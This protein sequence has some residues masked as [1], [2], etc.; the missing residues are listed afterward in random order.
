MKIKSKFKIIILLIGIAFVFN[1]T[2]IF[3]QQNEKVLVIKHKTKD[4][5]KYLKQGKRIIYWKYDDNKKHK[6]KLDSLGNNSIFV[7]DDEIT[8][9]EI[10][11]VSGNT[12]GMKVVN[13]SGG[14][15]TA[16]G[17]LISGLG[18]YI[19]FSPSKQ[20]TTDACQAAMVDLI[21]I[22]IGGVILITG[23]VAV[24]VGVIPLLV[25]NKRYSLEK[26]WELEVSD[27]VPKSKEKKL[28][29]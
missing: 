29:D 11:K 7:N 18:A 17:T 2:E 22:M 1:Q 24:V 3:A 20:E 12:I 19:L 26:D 23:A 21:K 15:L 13:V 4:K 10:S 25:H 14:L 16:S 8:F 6:G 9:R 28:K 5:A 27:V